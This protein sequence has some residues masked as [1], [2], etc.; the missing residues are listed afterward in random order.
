MK[1]LIFQAA[2]SETGG[3]TISVQ[4]LTEALVSAGVQVELFTVANSELAGSGT[5]PAPSRLFEV[6]RLTISK[7]IERIE[8]FGPHIVHVENTFPFLSSS[9]LR[10]LTSHRL[11]WVQVIRNYRASCVAGTHFRDGTNCFACREV[12]LPIPAVQHACLHD[13]RLKTLAGLRSKSATGRLNRSGGAKATV[14]TSGFIK[15]FYATENFPNPITISNP[16]RFPTP[17]EPLTEWNREWDF[18]FVGRLVE[19]KGCRLFLRLA[20]QNP[21]KSFRIAGH[22]PLEPEVRLIANRLANLSFEGS[23]SSTRADRL[24]RES[25]FALVPSL[26]NEPFGRVAIEAVAAGAVPVVSRLGGLGALVSELGTDLQVVQGETLM[27]WQS[28]LDDL[29]R[30]SSE[31]LNSAQENLFERASAAFEPAVIAAQ[32]I[33]LYESLT[34][35]TTSG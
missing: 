31:E 35:A 18:T 11:Q 5:L 16:V 32:F 8:C 13:S 33:K 15:S 21:E 12:R 19:E 3:E 22:G 26:W 9:L 20:E 10:V 29:E 25:R 6:K 27:D 30:L 24:F 34:S 28:K 14:F 17:G 7:L 23:V 2:Y 4:L 1:V